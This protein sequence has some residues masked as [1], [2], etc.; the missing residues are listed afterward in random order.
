VSKEERVFINPSDSCK[1]NDTCELKRAIFRNENYEIS[2]DRSD[3]FDVWI[4]STRILAGMETE[5]VDDLR[6]YAFVQFIRG[7][8]WY[9]LDRGDRIDTQFGVLRDF[10]G[11]KKMPFV[12]PNWAV[13]TNDT[14]P[15]YA[16]DAE[17]GD[18]HYFL[19]SLDQIPRWI[20]EH[21]GYLLGE[22]P[23]TVPFGYVRDYPGPAYYNPK[24][25]QA[26]NMSLEFEMCIFKTASLPTFTNGVNV[27]RKKALVCFHW[28]AQ[29]VFDHKNF[30][31][32]RTGKGVNKECSRPFTDEEK[33]V[34]RHFVDLSGESAEEH[35]KKK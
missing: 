32:N 19:E 22:K 9:S 12:I 27:D 11:L 7:C 21:A 15:I 3:P 8:M 2:R 6:K 35:Q 26:V 23:F 20:P 16:S 17:T 29:R 34:H 5:S 14:D 25:R 10:L 24:T 30:T 13:D 31:F 4:H 28:E 18:R 33:K 1:K